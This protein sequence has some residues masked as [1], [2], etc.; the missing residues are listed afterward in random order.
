LVDSIIREAQQFIEDERKSALASKSLTDTAV[1]AEVLRLREQNA[2]LIQLLETE[3]V[4]AERAK[5]E[6]LQ[7]VSG[8]LGEFTAER[9][10]SLRETFKVVRDGNEAA[11]QNM[12]EFA[13][14]H[15][16]VINEVTG[17]GKTWS[18]SL[19][20]R[21]GE[22]KRTRDGTLKVIVSRQPHRIIL[23][24][25][26]Q[27]LASSHSTVKDG[28]NSLR[29][30]VSSSMTSYSTDLHRSTQ[31]LNSTCAGGEIAHAFS[32]IQIIENRL[33]HTIGLIERNA[34]DWMPL[35]KWRQRRKPAIGHSSKA[36]LPRRRT[37]VRPW[38]KLSQR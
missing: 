15:A 18:E 25:A 21:A 20:K 27:T 37:L 7:R 33:Q 5:D 36:W 9:D 6:L 3:K 17:R 1:N 23:T 11:G 24:V 22:A 31:A 12:S 19:E 28:V 8:L 32:I 29:G 35:I 34:Q 30:Q 38:A 26:S 14:A 4:N 10:R 16:V 2:L 13:E